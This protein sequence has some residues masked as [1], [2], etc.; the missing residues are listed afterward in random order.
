MTGLDDYAE[1]AVATYDL[2]VEK[3]PFDS[4]GWSMSAV[5]VRRTNVFAVITNIEPSARKEDSH[6]L[7]QLYL[8]LVSR[9]W[10]SM[11]LSTSGR[12]VRVIPS[13]FW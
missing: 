12:S 9:L 6:V 8:V 3:A 2:T 1:V 11:Q 5:A 7:A 4:L 10:T 13:S